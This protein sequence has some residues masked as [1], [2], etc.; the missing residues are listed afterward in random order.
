MNIFH[1][2]LSPLQKF[3]T[4]FACHFIKVSFLNRLCC[5]ISIIARS[6]LVVIRAFSDTVDAQLRGVPTYGDP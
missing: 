2:R 5:S 6:S 1:F 4:Y 3:S